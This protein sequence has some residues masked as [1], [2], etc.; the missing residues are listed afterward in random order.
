M[1]CCNP[2]IPPGRAESVGREHVVRGPTFAYLKCHSPAAR[3]KKYR[4]VKNDEWKKTWHEEAAYISHYTNMCLEKRSKTMMTID[5]NSRPSN[6]D[7]SQGPT[8]RK[9][10]CFSNIRWIKSMKH[11]LQAYNNPTK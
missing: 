7:T 11:D 9:Q 10:E 1:S 3:K 2:T 5:Q 4:I 8:H 6:P